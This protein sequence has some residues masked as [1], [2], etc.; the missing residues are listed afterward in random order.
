METSLVLVKDLIK[1]EDAEF[2]IA[3]ESKFKERYSNSSLFR[4]KFEMEAMVLNEDEHPTPDSKYW[5]AI[6]EQAVHVKELIRLSFESKKGEADLDLL[7]AEKDELKYKLT[8]QNPANIPEYEKDKLRAKIKRKEVEIEEREFGLLEC[9]K[10]AKER[11][12]EVRDWEDLIPALESQLKHGKDDWEKH[13]PERYFKRFEKR[14]GRLDLIEPDAKENTV[15]FFLASLQHPENKGLADEYTAKLREGNNQQQELTLPP[16]SSTEKGLKLEQP[17]VSSQIDFISKEE[18]MEKDV[19]AKHYFSHK[20]RRI[21]VA[22]PHRNANDPNVT[23]FSLLQMPAAFDTM[24]EQPYGFTVPDARN[25]I[26][27]K[28]LEEGIEYIFFVDDDVVIP[29]NALVQLYNCKANVVGGM[30]YRKYIPLESVPMIELEDGTPSALEE[31]SIGD[32]FGNV[33]V[34]PSGC[35]LI[36]TDSFVKMKKPYYK[37]F[38]VQG[39]AAIT[40]DT[41]VCQRFRDQGLNV[42]LDT[43]IQCLHVDKS[44]HKIYGHPE[45]VNIETSMI[46]PK[47]KDYFAVKFDGA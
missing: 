4:S 17:K 7:H 11:I 22:T 14:I 40:E 31:Y 16:S 35:T 24:I 26:V 38:T 2:L 34:L 6:G 47:Y 28:A 19:V 18:L 27:D 20:V 1:P 15:K 43:G 9:K 25:F 21:M 23:D 3:H 41:Y 46:N 45:I 30:Y 8:K 39:K 42:I 12:R 10:V 44:N 29:R 33:L 37:T 32:I 13:H 5:Q 36:K